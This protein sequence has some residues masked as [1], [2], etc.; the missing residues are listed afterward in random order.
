[1]DPTH[2][3]WPLPGTHPQP[4]DL[5]PPGWPPPAGRPPGPPPSF[6]PPARPDKRI[7]FI[8]A[9]LALVCAIAAT[10]V[11]AFR[12]KTGAAAV[13]AAADRLGDQSAA[14][15]EVDYFD[16]RGSFV[17]GS[18]TLDDDLDATGKITDPVS[19]T[20][21]FVAHSADAAIRADA[22]WWLRRDPG[23]A[24]VLG[25]RWISPGVDPFPLDVIDTF[26]PDSLALLVGRIR[27][28]G[29]MTPPE[30][31]FRG[32]AVIGMTWDG[33][34]VL[35]TKKS[36]HR[37][38]W[39][40]GPITKSGPVRPVSWS[41]PPARP[42]SA[43]PTAVNPSFRYAVNP[44]A[45]GGADVR[46]ALAPFAVPQ[47]PYVSITVPDVPDDAAASVREAVARV[48]PSAATPGSGPAPAEPPSE[49]SVVP[50]A[51]RFETTANATDC[52]SPTCTWTVTVTN[53][54]DAPGEVSVLATVSPGMPTRTIS[55]GTLKPG[56]SRTTPPMTF[57][58]PAPAVPGRNTRI[59]ISYTADTFSPT[60]TGASQATVRRL[61]TR[62]IQVP[63]SS[64]LTDLPGPQ[65]AVTM[66]ALDLLSSKPGFRP[67]QVL[68][69]VENAVRNNAFPELQA[70]VESGRLVN[71]Q[72]LAEKLNNLTFEVDPDPDAPQ[73]AKDKIGYR[74]EVQ[75]AAETLR[76]Q[77]DARVVLD[78]IVVVEGRK[79][80]VDLLVRPKSPSDQATA[81]QIKTVSSSQL[82]K[83]LRS[84]LRQLNGKN[85]P[86]A[87][88][89]VSEQAPPGSKRVA[90]IFLEPPAG[91][92]HSDDRSALE[93]HLRQNRNE[94]LSDWC[95]GDAVQADEV[96]IVN[97]A[98]RHRWTSRQ[99]SAL[100]GADCA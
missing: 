47:P 66:K 62:G 60:L 79:Y 82:V 61:R 7:L 72:D 69:G 27:E 85:A 64:N 18:F 48:L 100:L 10:L 5:A 26:T 29:T 67:D 39:L 54:G 40:G 52:F 35:V 21:D 8:A 87:K 2:Q 14:A 90:L 77:P 25:K 80:K 34:T 65:S 12:D 3:Q 20:A 98:G 71:P 57:T 95:D 92:R 49:S 9:G 13:D 36:P 23:Q 99:L 81:F 58:N 11:L 22:A 93:H 78:G 17:S 74:R 63:P 55:I 96:V 44:L 73:P 19:G 1:M 70:L 16:P 94:L 89:G 88:T 51:P 38:L 83:R 4:G 42:R 84:S 6:P 97:Q 75:V 43:T 91:R 28:R 46:P 24:G 59:S 41:G 56:E 45:G 15:V 53:T 33:W 86:D 32:K 37:V 50:K 76:L 68:S 30:D 31:P